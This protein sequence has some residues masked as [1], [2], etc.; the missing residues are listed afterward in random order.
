MTRL[1]VLVLAMLSACFAFQGSAFSPSLGL[2]GASL[3]IRATSVRPGFRHGPGGAVSTK[4]I[5]GLDGNTAVGDPCILGPSPQSA[6][7]GFA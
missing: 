2:R 6:F 1:L 3:A 7:C 5:F 4:M